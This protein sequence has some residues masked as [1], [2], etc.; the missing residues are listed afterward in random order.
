MSR[1]HVSI[2]YNGFS[3][4]FNIDSELWKK[5]SEIVFMDFGFGAIKH[6]IG[7]YI[8][9]RVQKY[10]TANKGIEAF[11]EPN[12]VPKPEIDADVEQKILPWLRSRTND[13]LNKL[14]INSYRSFVYTQ[15]LL[16][17]PPDKRSTIEFDYETLW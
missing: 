12:Y 4:D 2:R 6:D 17:T 15:G 3:V 5:Y 1:K 14:R 11:F 13:E 10:Q 16:D 7:T 8:M 9:N